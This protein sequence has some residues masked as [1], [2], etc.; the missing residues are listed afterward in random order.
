ME[1]ILRSTDKELELS[2]FESE[3]FTVTSF[4]WQRYS[5]GEEI[6]LAEFAKE[7]APQLM[8]AAIKEIW[9]RDSKD[10]VCKNLTS[11]EEYIK[12]V[13]ECEATTTNNPYV[14][15]DALLH[16]VAVRIKEIAAAEIEKEKYEMI[17]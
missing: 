8:E 15:S 7:F 6:N 3:L 10:N 17:H 9:D 1:H 4:F 16:K 11:L 5:R 13:I 12:A 14:M 2:G